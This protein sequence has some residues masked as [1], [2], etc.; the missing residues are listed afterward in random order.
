ML[1]VQNEFRQ[2]TSM[3]EFMTYQLL[4]ICSYLD[5]HFFGYLTKYCE[6]YLASLI[7]RRF[8]SGSLKKHLISPPQSTGGVKKVAPRAVSI[9]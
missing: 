9:S 5:V 1:N 6:A 7:S 3:P 2:L 8:P 4:L